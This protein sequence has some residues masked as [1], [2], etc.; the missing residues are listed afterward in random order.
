M[1]GNVTGCNSIL[2]DLAPLRRD[3][4]LDVALGAR[5]R[6]FGDAEHAPAA[7][8]EPLAHL[9]ANASVKRGIADDAALADLVA[10]DLE[11]RL[12]Q[13]H[14]RATR[15]GEDERNLEDLGEADERRV[16]HHPVARP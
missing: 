1:A 14:Q 3:E 8:L 10:A 16:A 12:D 15:F 13:R 11:L 2:R 5:D 4:E 6:T 7:G 9:A